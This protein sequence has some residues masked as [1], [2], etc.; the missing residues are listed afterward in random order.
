MSIKIFKLDNGDD[1]IAM[2]GKGDGVVMDSP[3][4]ILSFPDPAT[5]SMGMML[6]P[7]CPYTEKDSFSIAPIHV[8]TEVEEEDIDSQLVREYRERFGSGLMTPPDKEIQ[9]DLIL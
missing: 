7:W 6:V 1:V 9:T 5:G 8:I 2:E 4:R 3:V